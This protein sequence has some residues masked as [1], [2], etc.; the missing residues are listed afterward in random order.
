MNVFKKAQTA[1]EY[2]IILAV[3]IIIALIVVGVM[4][5]IP[6]LGGNTRSRAQSSYW[7][8]ADVGVVAFTSGTTNRINLRNNMRD[9]IRINEF[10]LDGN[11]VTG[12]G[13]SGTILAPGEQKQYT[14]TAGVPNCLAAGDSFTYTVEINYTNAATNGNYTFD[15]DGNQLEG[16]CSS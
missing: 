4:G 3:I 8:S 10:A 5:G 15:G 1:T 2:M 14:L 11:N 13:G 12:L 9:A 16:K 6:G 7:Q